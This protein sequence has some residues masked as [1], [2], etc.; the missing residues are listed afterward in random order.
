MSRP[1]SPFAPSRLPSARARR[2][3]GAKLGLFYLVFAT[4]YAGTIAS[5]VQ[6]KQPGAL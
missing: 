5:S 2:G 1:A 6:A 3:G 4:L